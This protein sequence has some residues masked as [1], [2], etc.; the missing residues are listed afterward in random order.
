MDNQENNEYEYKKCLTCSRITQH[1]KKNTEYY[2]KWCKTK[3]YKKYMV[4]TDYDDCPNCGKWKTRRAITCLSCNTI[5]KKER[6]RLRKKEKI[7]RLVE[8]NNR[9]Y[10]QSRL[11]EKEYLEKMINEYE[12]RI[13]RYREKIK[14]IEEIIK[15]YE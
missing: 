7:V 11:R 12:D 1:E 5:Q 4:T 13:K 9:L 15:K 8:R 10:Y 2:C 6:I 3:Y 14:T